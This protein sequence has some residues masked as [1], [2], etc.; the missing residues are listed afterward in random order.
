MGKKKPLSLP[1]F[2][3]KGPNYQ[4]EIIFPILLEMAPLSPDE[5]NGVA[6]LYYVRSRES[7]LRKGDAI[8][9]WWRELIK[10]VEKKSNDSMAQAEPA[11]WAIKCAMEARFNKQLTPLLNNNAAAVNNSNDNHAAFAIALPASAIA[12]PAADVSRIATQTCDALEEMWDRAGM[13]PD[14]RE[15]RYSQLFRH[16]QKLCDLKVCEAEMEEAARQGGEFNTPDSAL[17]DRVSVFS[18]RV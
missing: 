14:E 17:A 1:A 11:L 18:F 10:K 4:R 7:E 16:F 9:R 15:R 8:S 6:D 2:F 12:T 5:W 13:P 3:V